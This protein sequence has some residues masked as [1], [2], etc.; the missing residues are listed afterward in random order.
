MSGLL[1]LNPSMSVGEQ[2]FILVMDAN[3]LNLTI[4][5]ISFHHWNS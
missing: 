3:M 4:L 2:G 1:E 5:D